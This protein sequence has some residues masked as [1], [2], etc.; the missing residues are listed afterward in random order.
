MK[1]K[2]KTIYWILD[3]LDCNV[4][5]AKSRILPKSEFV[6][7]SVL[8]GWSTVTVRRPTNPLS[9]PNFA[10]LHSFCEHQHQP[11]HHCLL[12]LNKDSFNISNPALRYL[13]CSQTDFLTDL[14]RRHQHWSSASS[15]QEDSISTKAKYSSKP[16]NSSNLTNFPPVHVQNYE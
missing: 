12:V 14:Q 13:F 4:L 1:K 15:D 16:S 8:D 11:Y 9:L 10:L 3:K 5:I 7:R 2:C 6:R